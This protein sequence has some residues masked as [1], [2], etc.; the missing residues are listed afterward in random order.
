MSA[1]RRSRAKKSW[2]PERSERA[3]GTGAVVEGF[4]GRPGMALV[5]SFEQLAAAVGIDALVARDTHGDV[6]SRASRGPFGRTRQSLRRI[7]RR[8]SSAVAL[9]AGVD[10]LPIPAWQANREDRLP[11]II[12]VPASA[13]AVRRHR[14]AAAG[15]WQ[16]RRATVQHPH[17]A[18]STWP[19]WITVGWDAVRA[20]RSYRWP[21]ASS[22]ACARRS[23]ARSG[24]ADA[25][26]AGR[27]AS[28]SNRDRDRDQRRNHQLAPFCSPHV[29]RQIAR[30]TC[31]ATG[32]FCLSS[33]RAFAWNERRVWH[34]FCR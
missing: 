17:G 5:A 32:D 9:H 23:I 20:A 24:I 26:S 19:A 30:A 7:A 22:V 18:A 16:G 4:N 21:A 15:S 2:S 29:G 8:S 11:A 14:A 25:V 3:S 12:R 34:V 31:T 6:T 27:C 13:E 33:A 10:H 28:T 1:S